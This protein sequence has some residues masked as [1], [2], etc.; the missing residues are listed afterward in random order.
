MMDSPHNFFF[1]SFDPAGF[2]SLDKPPV[3]LWIQVVS[4]KLFGFS[5][6]SVLVPQVVEGVVAIVLVSYLVQHRFGLLA[7]LL[8]ALFLALTPISVAID[9]SSNTDSCL[10]LVLLLAAWALTRAAEVGSWRLLL[11][12][13]ALVGVGFNVKM[14]AAFVVLP[15]FVVT[16][17]L[18]APITWRRRLSHSAM[19]SVVLAAV[20]LS[21]IVAYD[22]TPPESRP[23]VGSSKGNS[24]LELAIGHNGMER[25]VRRR[26]RPA[27]TLDGQP[28][29]NIVT[30]DSS[31]S[32]VTVQPAPTGSTSDPALALPSSQGTQ[33]GANPNAPQGADGPPGA[34]PSFEV[35]VPIGPLRL[36]DRH[37]ASQGSWLLPL[38][39]HVLPAERVV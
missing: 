29:G 15:T 22:L 5:G 16:Y 25:F 32:N 8:A 33:M 14:L 4:A 19:A 23:F 38:V 21:W 10:V 11:L 13:M 39:N 34:R 31:A 26:G 20:S 2:V 27:G 30:P 18:G 24:M 1:N 37:L 3:A 17:W 36:A 9:R 28:A 35:E 7:G 12:S 6:L